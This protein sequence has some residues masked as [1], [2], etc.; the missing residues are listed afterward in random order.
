MSADNQRLHAMVSA[1]LAAGGRIR[2]MPEAVPATPIDVLRYLKRYKVKV[3]PTRAK[4]ANVE[5]KYLHEGETITLDAL[6]QLANGY[7]REQ[8]LPP[9]EVQ[10]PAQH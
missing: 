1:Y 6:V 3:E 4:N 10:Q 8:D 5:S 2:K 7:R 9:F